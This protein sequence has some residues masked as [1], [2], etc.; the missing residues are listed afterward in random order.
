MVDTTLS[1]VKSM[2]TRSKHIEEME[3]ELDIWIE[4]QRVKKI[5]NNLSHNQRDSTI[6]IQRAQVKISNLQIPQKWL[7]FMLLMPGLVISNI[8]I[9]FKYFSCQAYQKAAEEFW[10]MQNLMQMAILWIKF[11][12]LM[13]QVINGYL[14]RHT[15]QGR[16]HLPHDS[17]LRKVT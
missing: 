11:A 8:T 9:V 2:R 16:K 15:S 12:V 3:L 17:R 10:A 13:K 4:D 5:K 14:E 7:I 1:A 6:Y